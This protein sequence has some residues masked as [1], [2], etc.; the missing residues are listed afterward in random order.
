MAVVNCMGCGRKVYAFTPCPDCGADLVVPAGNVGT[1]SA[2]IA[3]PL[4]EPTLL[5]ME[6]ANLLFMA[7]LKYKTVMLQ[8]FRRFRGK[9]KRRSQKRIGEAFDRLAD[10]VVQFHGAYNALLTACAEQGVE[11]QALLEANP[12]LKSAVERNVDYLAVRSLHEVYE[13][14]E[15]RF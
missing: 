12:K 10:T 13:V 15:G 8:E 5:F 6:L 4:L 14:I 2:N 3:R 11:W 1:R 7:E 9:V